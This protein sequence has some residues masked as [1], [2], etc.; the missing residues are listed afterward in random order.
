PESLGPYPVTNLQYVAGNG[1]SL[2]DKKNEA[3]TDKTEDG[4]GKSVK[5][6]SQQAKIKLKFNKSKMKP[7]L[8]KYYMGKPVPI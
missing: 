7:K 1:Y 5:C 6:Q 3:K 4:N 8:K 2:K